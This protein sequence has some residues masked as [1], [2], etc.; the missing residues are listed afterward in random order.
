MEDMSL[1]CNF[2]LCEFSFVRRNDNG[3]AH[4]L[5]SE[6][7]GVGVCM[8]EAYPPLWLST[9]LMKYRHALLIFSLFV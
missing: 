7:Y 4:C 9:P 5:A 6:G 1:A 3:V 8:W 2:L